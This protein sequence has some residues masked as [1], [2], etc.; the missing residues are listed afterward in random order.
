MTDVTYRS[1]FV[2]LIGRP[3]A[4]KSTLL[5]R[6]LGQKLA[7]TSRRPHTT[8]HLLLGIHTTKDYQIVFVD[9][10]GM[11]DGK[12]NSMNRYI[13]RTARASLLGVD[14]VVV[15]ISPRGWTDADR[16]VLEAATREGVPVIV[17]INK[18][19]TLEDREA[20]L[21]LLSETSDMFGDS[22]KEVVPISA[23][24]G[25]NLD[26]LEQALLKYLP[27]QPALFPED[28]VTDRSLR[29]M[30]SEFVREQ[31][32]RQLGQE[33]P[34]AT[35]VSIES[36]KDEPKLVHIEAI[37]WVERSGQKAIIIGKKGARLKEIGSEAR[38]N[39]QQLVGKKINL[40]L[41]VKVRENWRDNEAALRNL[42]FGED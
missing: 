12:Q 13:N 23:L 31:I 5:N 36:W 42:G 27:L 25:D 4:G 33:V 24:K 41:W 6:L 3:N 32:F 14:A 21:P 8:R 28:Q 30:A 40:Q 18:I 29:F 35:A 22:V 17:A 9:T 15:L 10:P 37:I 11:H 1:G 39:L 34:H 26:R 2:A 16:S 7:I 19:D 20:L 38:K